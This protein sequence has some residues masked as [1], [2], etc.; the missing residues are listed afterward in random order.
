MR[1]CDVIALRWCVPKHLP[2]ITY[3][4]LMRWEMQKRLPKEI[5]FE[6]MS[7]DFTTFGLINLIKAFEREHH[8]WLSSPNETTEPPP[9]EWN[10]GEALRTDDPVKGLR[11]LRRV[12]LRHSTVIAQPGREEYEVIPSWASQIAD[13]SFVAIQFMTRRSNSCMMSTGNV[14]ENHSRRISSL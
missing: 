10:L 7:T 4:T 14:I 13:N 2:G 6:G 5:D 12:Q 9:V 1:H 3:R 8:Q 11:S